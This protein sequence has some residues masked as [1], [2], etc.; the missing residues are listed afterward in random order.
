LYLKLADVLT[1]MGD[2]M[3]SQTMCREGL[4]LANNKS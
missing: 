3:G 2:F 1:Q 4:L